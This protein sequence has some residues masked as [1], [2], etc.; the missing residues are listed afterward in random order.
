[1]FHSLVVAIRNFL[2]LDVLKGIHMKYLMDEISLNNFNEIFFDFICKFF[3]IFET[4]LG[5]LT[6][7][8]S[9]DH[10]ILHFPVN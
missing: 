5:C 4:F 9:G 10:S 7:N 8:T 1:M 6:T 3:L 2:S